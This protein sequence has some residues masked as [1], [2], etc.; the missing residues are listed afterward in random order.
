MGS[1]PPSSPAPLCFLC[2]RYRDSYRC[3]A[4]PEGI[5]FDVIASELDHRKEIDGDHGLRYL[6]VTPV[7]ARYAEDL[8]AA[9]DLEPIVPRNLRRMPA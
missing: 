6:P 5:P 7:A 8:F 2:A 3:E 9:P 4:F 1:T